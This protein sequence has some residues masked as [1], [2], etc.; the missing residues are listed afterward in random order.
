MIIKKL[1]RRIKENGLKATLVH[2]Y[3]LIA[4]LFINNTRKF[5]KNAKF[6]LPLR[7]Y[8]VFECESDMDDNPRAV[9]EYMIKNNYNKK[10]KLVWLVKNVDFCKKNYSQK[11]VVFIS[12][13]DSSAR[14]QFVLNYY[15]STAKWFIFSHP[16]WFNKKNKKQIIINTTHGTPFKGKTASSNLGNTFD[17]TLTASE[18]TKPW[19][20]KI[21]NCDEKQAFVCS[22]PRNDFLFDADKNIILN[23]LFNWNPDEKVI[24]CMPTF[25]QSKFMHDCDADDPY[26]LTVVETENE[27]YKLNNKL[28]NNKI[29]LIVKLHPLQSTD[30]LKIQNLSNIH[31]IQNEEL[32]RKKIILYKLLGYCDALIT[33]FSSVLFDYLELNRPIGFFTK[34]FDQYNRGYIMDNPKDYYVG[35]SIDTFENLLNFIDNLSNNIDN[36]KTERQQI[37][38]VV[39]NQNENNRCESF[40]KIMFELRKK[41]LN[42]LSEE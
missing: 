6:F 13:L 25:K 3:N 18:Y 2:Y 26:S 12:R 21:L 10:Y 22:H 41:Y 20:V 11:N 1:I 32:F 23:Q 33:D 4:T 19:F 5:A 30:V 9:Y 39:N 24:M 34:Y 42:N 7:N 27:L 14:N 8:I 40:V 31:Y 38:S 28:Y 36:F 16:Y 15:L 29:H 37:H 35:E 17:Y